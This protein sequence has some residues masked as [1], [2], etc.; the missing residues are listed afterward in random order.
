MSICS[1]IP[2]EQTKSAKVIFSQTT[3]NKATKRCRLIL[4]MNS[5]DLA[6]I[7]CFLFFSVIC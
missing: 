5:A 7:K 4:K 2:V 6:Q 3:F 1:N